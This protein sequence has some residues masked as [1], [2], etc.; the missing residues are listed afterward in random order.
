M[1]RLV[2]LDLT[3]DALLE[4]FSGKMW[5][6]ADKHEAGR[7]GLSEIEASDITSRDPSLLFLRGER[8]F[9]HITIERGFDFIDLT[10]DPIY[11]DEEG[12]MQRWLELLAQHV[13]KKLPGAHCLFTEGYSHTRVSGHVSN[14]F[15][16][17]VKNLVEEW[18]D[19]LYEQT[20]LWLEG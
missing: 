9:E 7:F 1:I 6:E 16:H 2:D 4:E 14:T 8:P 13:S 5:S 20:E 12:I 19:D 10:D 18:T 17:E 3:I 11:D 15:A